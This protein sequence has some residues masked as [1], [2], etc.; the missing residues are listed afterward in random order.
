MV[1]RVSIRWFDGRC[2]DGGVGN[3]CCMRRSSPTAP[4][5]SGAT[6]VAGQLLIATAALR[7]PPFEHAVILVAQHNK[8][9]ALGIVINRPLGERSDRQ[10]AARRSARMRAGS[11]ANVRCISAARS[12]RKSAS[13]CT[14]PT[15]T[16]TTRRHRWARGAL[17]RAADPARHRSRQRPAP[18]PGR[19]RLRRLGDRCSSTTSC[20]K[21]SGPPC[22]KIRLWFSTTTG[23][24]SGPMRWRGIS[25]TECR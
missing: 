7:G 13:C 2:G 9:G 24:R 23:P 4:D 21:A 6:S 1:S 17:K 12:I 22:R 11:A 15:I 16:A 5:V 25:R 20:A 10:P 14:A 8:D 19:F 3:A 18:K